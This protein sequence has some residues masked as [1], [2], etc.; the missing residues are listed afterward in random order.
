MLLDTCNKQ[1]GSMHFWLNTHGKKYTILTRVRLSNDT[2]KVGQLHQIN[3]IQTIKVQLMAYSILL[4]FRTF[5]K[6]SCP[7]PFRS[8]KKLWSGKV[9]AKSLQISFSNGETS[10]TQTENLI[11]I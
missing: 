10:Y 9:R 8:L 5:N 1:A 2:I 7:I 3:V 11:T 6:D 4:T